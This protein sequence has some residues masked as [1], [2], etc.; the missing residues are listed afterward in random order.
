MRAVI[1]ALALLLAGQAACAPIADPM[2]AYAAPQR[3]VKLP[4]GR[5]MN[6]Y[7][8]GSKGP[9]VILDAG[10]GGSTFSWGSLQ[11][12]LS[13][14]RAC[15]YDRAGMGFSDPGPL[16]RDVTHR[17]ADLA[18]LLKASG[19]PGPYILVGHSLG[20]LDVRMFAFQHPKAVTGLVLV[21][22]SVE[23]QEDRIAALLGL[24]R[25]P[26]AG[27]P[28]ACLA[29]TEAGLKPGTPEYDRCAG[30]YP[31]RWPQALKDA[32]VAQRSRPD[33]FR[34]EVSELESLADADGA[35]IDQ[36][37]RPLGDMPLIVLTA[38]NTYRTG[39]PDVVAGALSK[40]WMS[41][42]DEL[43]QASTRGQNRLVQGSGHLIQNDNPVAVAAAIREVAAMAG[44]R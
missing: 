42:H 13:G 38:E 24:P 31:D 26:L 16:P 40:L 22:P 2:M 4:D 12:K 15:S 9:V 3:L 35:Q 18:A 41:M 8:T 10:F 21:D 43:A 20:G 32:F 37:R 27:A 39:V 30:K 44:K 23:H 34:T 19:L 33:Y 17:A 29:A 7:C 11:P 14:F 6:L 5:R 25:P 1:L 36:A 28:K